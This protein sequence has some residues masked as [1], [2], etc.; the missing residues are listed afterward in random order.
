MFLS[1]S[2]FG[3]L[4]QLNIIHFISILQHFSLVSIFSSKVV[5]SR[6]QQFQQ[7][8]TKA[9]APAGSATHSSKAGCQV[10]GKSCRL[11][12]HGQST[13]LQTLA[14]DKPFSSSPCNPSYASAIICLDTMSSMDDDGGSSSSTRDR[15]PA[16]PT[17][18]QQN[19]SGSFAL[20]HSPSS[21]LHHS[22]SS[23][24]TCSF[25]NID[26]LPPP[27]WDDETKMLVLKVHHLSMMSIYLLG[28]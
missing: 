7:H 18:S 23:G 28:C 26:K 17:Q 12:K 16:A 1:A 9:A 14:P 2:M 6:Q 24:L 8:L 15:Q 22:I 25:A 10:V 5:T 4:N 13:K 11:T 20:R 3:P 19:M 21:G 27:A